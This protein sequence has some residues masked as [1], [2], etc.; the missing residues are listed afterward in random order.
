MAWVVKHLPSKYKAE[1]KKQ[2]PWHCQ[3]KKNRVNLIKIHYM[4][5]CKYHSEALLSH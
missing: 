5:V 1:F 2:T 3:K 4:H